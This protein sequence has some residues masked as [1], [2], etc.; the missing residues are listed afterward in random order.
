MTKCN[1]DNCLSEIFESFGFTGNAIPYGTGHINDT[2]L[3]NAT[4]GKKYIVQRINNDIFKK[5]WELMDNVV[6]VTAHIR[7]K[8]IAQGQ[9]PERKV[10]NFLKAKDG[11]YYVE[12]KSGK[13]FRAYEYVDGVSTY[14]IVEKPEDFYK[15]AKA[16]GKFQNQLSD[17]PAS[18]LYE[19]IPN[20]HNTRSRYEDFKKAVKEDR[21]G[22]L[23]DVKAE[24]EFYL[25]READSDIVVDAMAQGKIPVRVTHNDTKLNN[26]LIDN[27]TNEG[28]CVIDLD[29]VMPGSLLYDF[30]D[31]MRFGTNTAAEDEKDL[32]KVTSDLTY[33]EYFTKG[34]LEELSNSITKEEIELL[35]FSAKLLT[36]ECGTRFLADHLN[37]DTY[38]KIHREGHNLDR[39]RTQMKLVADMESKMDKMAAIVKKYI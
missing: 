10:L 13:F 35:P 18:K 36:L 20:F 2:Y 29:T 22:R 38:F 19:T 15:A 30:G 1:N 28:I 12:T 6:A 3:I 7:S 5:P 23:K 37:G 34:F 33:F 25:E 24:V 21:C 32:S 11:K 8:I 4:N 27:A 9:N 26:V 14:D 39:A 17:F 16:F 31:S